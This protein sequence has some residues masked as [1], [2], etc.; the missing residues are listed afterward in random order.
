MH[1]GTEPH[2]APSLPQHQCLSSS[3]GG[4]GICGVCTEVGAQPH[5]SALG[6]PPTSG[7]TSP[8]PPNVPCAQ[9]QSAPRAGNHPSPDPVWDQGLSSACLPVSAVMGRWKQEDER[10]ASRQV[11]RTAAAADDFMAATSQPLRP[12]WV[13]TLRVAPI[14]N[15]NARLAATE[16]LGSRC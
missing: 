2:G 10:E 7:F 16:A 1:P 13:L 6:K 4:W 11:K 9:M 12:C 5:L 14:R 3:L 8:L 15:A